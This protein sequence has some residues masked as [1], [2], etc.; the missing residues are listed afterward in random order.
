MK[1]NIKYNLN[2]KSIAS[3]DNRVKQLIKWIAPKVCV[4]VYLNDNV[5]CTEGW[6]A[7]Y[8]NEDFKK[9]NRNKCLSCWMNWLKYGSN[10]RE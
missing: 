3:E 1:H 8:S 4:H 9:V 5:W 10:E 2:D 7:Q 6:K